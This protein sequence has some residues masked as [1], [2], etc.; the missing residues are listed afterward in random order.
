VDCESNTDFGNEA[1]TRT[2]SCPVAFRG[3]HMGQRH[4]RRWPALPKQRRVGVAR[5]P[6]KATLLIDRL[7]QLRSS[8]VRLQLQRW[9]ASLN[10]YTRS[11]GYPDAEEARNDVYLRGAAFP[12][13]VFTVSAPS[14]HHRRQAT[15]TP[16]KNATNSEPSGAS[17]A[18]LLKGIPG[19]RPDSIASPTRWTV[20]FTASETSAMVDLGS[21]TGST[22]V[23]ERGQRDVI[24]HDLI[25]KFNK[26]P[27]KH[28]VNRFNMA[29]LSAIASAAA[30]RAA[31]AS[32]IAPMRSR[33]RPRLTSSQADCPAPSLQSLASRHGKYRHCARKRL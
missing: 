2:E 19:F 1:N 12:A 10:C 17:R 32:S 6:M 16:N 14:N 4:R 28:G 22:F 11:H 7:D 18:M 31:G 20:S 23:G 8:Q 3:R 13:N 25:S 15:A 26:Q 27:I 33:L 21:G 9:K 24:A 29:I 30:S 5:Q